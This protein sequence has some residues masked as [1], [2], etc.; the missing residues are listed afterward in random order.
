M[1][2]TDSLDTVPVAEEDYAKT[3]EEIRL[4]GVTSIYDAIRIA[5]AFPKIWAPSD[6]TKRYYNPPFVIW[7]RGQDCTGWAI[8]PSVF[9]PVNRENEKHE[10]ENRWFDETSLF[11]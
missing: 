1:D 7:Y 11:H 10:I 9:R 6:D 4:S 8:E 2:D 5:E 3:I